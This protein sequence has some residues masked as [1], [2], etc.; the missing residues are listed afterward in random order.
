MQLRLR[1][2]VVKSY[3]PFPENFEKER[4]DFCQSVNFKQEY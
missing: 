3:S 4:G 1:H 2:H